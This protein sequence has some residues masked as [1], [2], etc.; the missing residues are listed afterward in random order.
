MKSLLSYPMYKGIDFTDTLK[1]AIKRGIIQINKNGIILYLLS[2]GDE[3]GEFPSGVYDVEK[4]ENPHSKNESVKNTSY[5]FDEFRWLGR[6]DG[7][8]IPVDVRYG[9]V[10]LGLIESIP[11]GYVIQMV[12]TPQ[13]K[14][15]IKQGG[16]N[17]FKTKQDA[18][19]T[20]H[21]AWKLLRTGTVPS[22]KE[23]EEWKT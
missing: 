17:K 18:A 13:G 10:Y 3:I 16:R 14:Q 5:K 8:G 19:E 7:F 23:G 9:T 22:D 21:K 12:D 2:V 11:D 4:T 1:N 20:L 15:K 6:G